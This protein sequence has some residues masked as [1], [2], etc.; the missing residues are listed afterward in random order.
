MYL[1]IWGLWFHP[2]WKTACLSCPSKALGSILRTEMV[3]HACH[4]S[5][6]KVEEGGSEEF[7]VILGYMVHLRIAQPS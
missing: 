6:R 5:T 4:P 7:E 3:A 1:R 2:S